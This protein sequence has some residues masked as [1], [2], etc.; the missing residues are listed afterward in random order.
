MTPSPIREILPATGMLLAL[1]STPA[2]GQTISGVVLDDASDS[3]LQNVEVVLLDPVGDT[4]SE[5]LTSAEGRFRMELPQPGPYAISG[6]LLG[7]APITSEVLEFGEED[8]TVEIR[9]NMQALTLEPIIVQGEA[10]PPSGFLGDFYQRME[11]G[12]F[13]HF[14]SREE[15]ESQHAINATDL[16][17]MTPGVRVTP[18]R[19]GSGGIVRMTRGCVPAIYI[20]GMMINRGPAA[21]ASLDDLI[22][23]MDIEGIEVYRGAMSQVDGFYDPTGCGL[24]LVWSRRG[25]NDGGP[26]SW[27]KLFAGLGLFG[28][29]L[30]LGN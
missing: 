4:V 19:L 5:A 27:R 12:A 13:G 15:I 30:L 22:N 29:L 9:M 17:R 3:P 21:G 20:D 28:A 1:L 8:L 26:F 25:S 23:A 16:L 11:R 10:R 2:A 6:T 7:Y 14:I 18:G 24:I